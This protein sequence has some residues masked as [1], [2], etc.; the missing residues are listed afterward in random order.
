MHRAATGVKVALVLTYI[1]ARKA[2]T[3]FSF[4]KL[5]FQS[6][7]QV[8]EKAMFQNILVWTASFFADLS[9]VNCYGMCINR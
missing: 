1:N 8:E 5:G 9:G 3:A 4:R 6:T 7:P 2:K